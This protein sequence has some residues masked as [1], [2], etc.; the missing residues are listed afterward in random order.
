[1]FNFDQ[2][3]PIDTNF[4]SKRFL[5]MCIQ[6]AIWNKTAKAFGFAFFTIEDKTEYRQ[7]YKREV[8]KRLDVTT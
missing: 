7:A 2:S 4:K 8:D 5:A 6:I 3:K 1:M